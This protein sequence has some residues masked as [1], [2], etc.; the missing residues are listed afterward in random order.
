MLQALL[1]RSGNVGP[2]HRQTVQF[3][4]RRRVGLPKM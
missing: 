3:S 1:R 2:Q 4:R